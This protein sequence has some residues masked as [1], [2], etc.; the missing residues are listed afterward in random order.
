LK[1][2]PKELLMA[3]NEQ[4][5]EYN[6]SGQIVKGFEK[7]STRSRYDEDHVEKYGS[8]HTSVWGSFFDMKDGKWGYACCR[9]PFRSSYCTGA[10]G[11]AAAQMVPTADDSGPAKSLVD[12]HMDRMIASMKQEK[13]V[14]R[15]RDE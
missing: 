13:A 10:A 2:P 15:K 7:A 14:K 6:R 8:G 5:T 4:Y 9:S 11:L 1:A 12:Q 3:Q